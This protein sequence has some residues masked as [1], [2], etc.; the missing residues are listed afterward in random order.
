[1]THGKTNCANVHY[2]LSQLL[3]TTENKENMVK[4][5]EFAESQLEKNKS[6]EVF[7]EL[8]QKEKYLKTT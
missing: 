8:T 3:L 6:V 2:K 7:D 5:S 4:Q 1:M